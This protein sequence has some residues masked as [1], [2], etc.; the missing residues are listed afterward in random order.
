MTIAR[1]SALGGGRWFRATAA[2]L[3]GVL[4][5]VTLAPHAALANVPV[6]TALEFAGSS[7]NFGYAG[8]TQVTDSLSGIEIDSGGFPAGWCAVTIFDWKTSSGHFDPRMTK[9]CNPSYGISASSSDAGLGRTLIGMQRFGVCYGPKASTNLTESR[10]TDDSR[11][12]GS[13]VRT[14][15]GGPNAN[16]PNNCARGWRIEAGT[17]TVVYSTGGS[18]SSC[19][20]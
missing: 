11:V 7:A 15:T 17:S 9:T 16:L 6:G 19:T 10:C 5:A 12:E 20:S 2:A 1:G 13:V 3:A 4:A 14:P 8:W 18:S